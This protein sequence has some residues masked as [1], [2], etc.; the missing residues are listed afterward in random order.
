LEGIINDTGTAGTIK[1]AN[2]GVVSGLQVAARDLN[3]SIIDFINGGSGISWL[4]GSMYGLLEVK[5]M[6]VA[7]AV[8][9]I[10]AQGAVITIDST[11][12]AGT[13]QVGG[14]GELNIDNGVTATIVNQLVRGTLLDEHVSDI[15]AF[16]A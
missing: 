11:C 9:G 2:A 8:F 1:I 4:V 14:V 3:G 12:S 15:V 5:N 13:V 10:A 6:T 7:S 16:V